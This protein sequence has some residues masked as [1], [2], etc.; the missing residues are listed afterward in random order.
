PDLR[1]PPTSPAASSSSL[2]AHPVANLRAAVL[3]LL[4]D[5]GAYTVDQ[6]RNLVGER[7]GGVLSSPSPQIGDLLWELVWQG[8][9]TNDSYAPVR[10]MLGGGGH[11]RGRRPVASRRSRL[12]PGLSSRRGPLPRSPLDAR[13]GGRWSLLEHGG[14]VPTER[15]L[16]RVE[17]LVA[18]HGV[19]TRGSVNEEGVPGGFSA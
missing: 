7:S 18:R 8:V 16:T 3:E 1:Q 19:L 6:L 9:L 13:L 5:G 12:R 14:V 11:A 15:M 2:G 17:V 4:Q 10:A